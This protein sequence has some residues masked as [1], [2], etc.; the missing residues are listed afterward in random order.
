LN[1]T[2]FF[3]YAARRLRGFLGV[4]AAGWVFGEGLGAYFLGSGPHYPTL[5]SKG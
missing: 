5:L 3:G 4:L 1:I 2:A